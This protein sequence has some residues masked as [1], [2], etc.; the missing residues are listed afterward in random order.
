MNNPSLSK[1]ERWMMS[2]LLEPA[3]PDDAEVAARLI[4]Q[5]DEELFRYCTGGSLD[6]WVTLAKLE[7]GHRRGIYSYTLADV[8]RSGP[9]LQG[10]ILSYS[11]S[12]H[13]EIDWSLGSSA[14]KLP[15][16]LLERLRSTR[17]TASFLFPAIREGVWYIQNI[18]VIPQTQGTGLGRFLMEAIFERARN[19]GCRECHL[20]VDS[21]TQAVHFYR[22][23]G[24]KI[25][26]ET[27]VPDIAAVSTHY[28]MV[29]SLEA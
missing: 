29:K 28:R 5:T 13:L 12:R 21:S 2:F 1:N 10:L 25:M 24:M 27:R 3:L 15:P 14:P 17:P 18:A 4:T 7:W 11:Y 19:E 8:V 9:D 26:V 22:K 6:D 16:S 23:L 20:D